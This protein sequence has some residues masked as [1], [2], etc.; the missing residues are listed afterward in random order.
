MNHRPTLIH[1]LG[2]DMPTWFVNRL[3]FEMPA[4][5]D[6]FISA[7]AAII[8]DVRQISDPHRPAQHSHE[9]QVHCRHDE[10]GLGL[11]VAHAKRL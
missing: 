3:G 5:P 6:E 10:V 9:R 2:M 8:D 4:A 11:Q 7:M 1:R